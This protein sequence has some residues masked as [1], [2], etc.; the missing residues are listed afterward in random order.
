MK[1]FFKVFIFAELLLIVCIV[2]FLTGKR[3]SA[4]EYQEKMTTLVNELQSEWKEQYET[5]A[6]GEKSSA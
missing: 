5:E 6:E 4:K 2:S 3:I 1:K